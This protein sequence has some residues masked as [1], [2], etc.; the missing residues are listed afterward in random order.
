MDEEGI[1]YL[2][3]CA[4][5]MLVVMLTSSVFK[6]L[7][8]IAI[9]LAV[10]GIALLL[11]LT[12][13]DYLI[14]PLVTKMLGIKFSPAKDYAIVPD[15][16]AIVKE[17]GG[18]FYAT[19]F[20]TASVFSY[21]FKEGSIQENED[22]QVI[23]SPER[24]ERAVMSINFP[25]K[26]HILAASRSVQ[27]VREEIEGKRS[28]QEFQLARALQESSAN[29]VVITNIQ[30]NISVLQARMDRI[31]RGE[32]PLSALMYIES[33]AFGVSEKAA[34]DALTEQ[35][36]QLQVAFSAFDISLQRIVG[37]EIYTLFL[38]NF[39]LP[40]TT[41]AAESNFDMQG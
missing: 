28:Y 3:I 18:I 34:L 8:I 29:E 31:S 39:S 23:N 14:F 5:L 21:T 30:R 33:T 20:L 40:F 6:P 32:R 12:F 19:G 17:V 9:L 37:R 4:S 36:N 13:A 7:S 2:G 24:W 26:Y 22:E 38:Y 1:F 16:T 10:A 27:E 15:Q 41:A 11:G 35:V 25:F